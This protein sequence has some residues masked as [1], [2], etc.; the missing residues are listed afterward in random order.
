MQ[1]E[2]LAKKKDAA[3]KLRR[4]NL[5]KLSAGLVIAVTV[6]GI[7]TACG[8]ELGGGEGNPAEHLA[9]IL[10]AAGA[11]ATF[12]AGDAVIQNRYHKL[13]IPFKTDNGE[14][15]QGDKQAAPLPG[16]NQLFVKHCPDAAGNLGHN[17]V[18]AAVTD[19]LHLGIQ[20]HWIQDLHCGHQF[21]RQ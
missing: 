15:P 9:G 20:N 7:I 19:F 18:A 12:L 8:M 16:E 14:L 5:C 10:R 2:I 4:Q 1:F 21:D 3:G 17:L 6:T 13:C 11:F